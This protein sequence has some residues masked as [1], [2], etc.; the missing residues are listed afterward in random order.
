LVNAAPLQRKDFERFIEMQGNVEIDKTGY[1]SSEMGGRITQLSVREGDFITEVQ[2]ALELATTVYQK[3]ER[4]WQQNIGTEIEYLAA[5][6]EKE[7]LEK[8]ILSVQ[9]Q[10]GKVNVYS[11]MTGI[12]DRVMIKSRCRPTRN[13]LALGESR[14]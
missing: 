13:L 10:L 12:V 2:K 8:S 11:P 9:S 7:R 6:N 14:G 5:K 1:A 3:R 4:L